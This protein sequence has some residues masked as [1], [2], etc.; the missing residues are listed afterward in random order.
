MAEPTVGGPGPADPAGP[1]PVTTVE[2]LIRRRLSDALGG[3]RGSLETT[4]PMLAFVIVWASTADA[5]LSLGAAAGLTVLLLLA[6][7]A[8]RQTPQFVLT[9][10]VATGLAAFFALR[11]GNAEDAF[12]PGILTSI[13]WGIGALLSVL[14]R[15]PVVGFMIGA[16]DPAIAEGDPFRWRR[17]PA[18][19]RVCSRLTLV[20]VG[21]YAIRVAIMGP[22]YLAGNIAAL[23]VAKVVLGWPL[24]A[25]AVVVMGLLLVRGRTPIDPDDELVRGHSLAADAQREHGPA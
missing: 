17:N 11:S 10:V 20:L 7:L 12:L 14:L 4:L 23:T 3:V 9:S 21:L 15:W 18:A 13:A 8:Q 22:L 25:G 24:W 2:E 5:R 6:R 16:A 19:V 1:L